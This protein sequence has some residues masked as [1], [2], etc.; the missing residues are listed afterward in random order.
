MISIGKKKKKILPKS[1]FVVLS[2]ITMWVTKSDIKMVLSLKVT[3][4]EYGNSFHKK[5][6]VR[7]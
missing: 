3:S 6:I 2:A 1:S 7:I 5:G 4:L